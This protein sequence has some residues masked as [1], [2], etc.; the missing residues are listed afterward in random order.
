MGKGTE[1]KMTIQEDYEAQM[2]RSKRASEAL[3]NLRAI[4]EKDDDAAW[5]TVRGCLIALS[6]DADVT[7]L[8]ERDFDA[9]CSEQDRLEIVNAICALWASRYHRDDLSILAMSFSLCPMHF[10]DWAIC[11]DD[12]DPDCSQIRDIFPTHHDT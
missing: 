12:Q 2:A 1:T 7:V 10:V 3:E 5:S 11:F 4:L 8:D 6:Y 9:D